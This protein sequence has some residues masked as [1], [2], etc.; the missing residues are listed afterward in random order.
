LSI[1]ATALNGRWNGQLVAATSVDGHNWIYPVAYGFISSETEADWTWFMERLQKAI[2][3]LP[4]LAISSDACKGLENAV[5]KVFPNAEQRECFFH[6]T[7]NFMKKFRGFGQLSPAARAYREDIFYEKIAS[8]I[9]ESPEPVQ[10]L[11]KNHKLLWYR[12]AFNPEI[13]CDYITNNISES[14]NNRIRD[15]KDLPICD[16]ADKIRGY[17]MDLWYRRR[18]IAYRLPEGRILPAIMVQLKA[19]TRGLGHLKI[20]PSADWSAEVWDHSGSIADIL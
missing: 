8:I 7:K 1:D 3:N 13:K 17:I 4:V 12:C 18:N 19:N 20:A 2:G 15:Y 9:S 10:W 14:F 6:L 11:Q 16:L 5:K